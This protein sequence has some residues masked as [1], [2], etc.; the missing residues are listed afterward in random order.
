MSRSNLFT[1][2]TYQTNT[3]GW[4]ATQ[5]LNKRIVNSQRSSTTATITTDTDHGF[6]VGDSVTISGTN[7]NSA[8]HG[9]YT[10][11]A[12][13]TS[14]TFR[15]TTATSGTIT[16][17]ADTGTATVFGLAPSTNTKTIINSER[18]STTALITTSASHGFAVGDVV[19][20]AGTN[21]NTPLHGTYT[22]TGV[23][24]DTTFTY[25][26]STSGSI[27]SA[28]DTGTAVI[29]TTSL[30]RITSDYFV[31]SSSLEITKSA[32]ANSGVITTNRVA[33]TALSKYAISG[34]VKVPS[35]QESGSFNIKA[36]WY[37]AS[38]A[39]SIVLVSDGT[40]T[41]STS[42]SGWKR[43]TAVFTAP[44][45][46]THANFAFIQTTAGTS[47]K[48]FLLDAVLLEEATS[49]GEFF[50]NSNQAN[51]TSKVNLSLTPLPQP[52]L[53]GMKLQ[54]DISLNDFTFNTID[55][56]GVVWVVTDLGGWW[57]HP[58]SEI[59]DIARGWGDGSYDVKGRYNAR[60]IT[61]EGVILTPD[62]SLLAAARD[63]LVAA[64]NLVHSGAWLKTNEGSSVRASYVRL[65]G[66]V[67]IQTV[68]ARGRTEFSIGLRA[69][70]PIK[71]KWNTVDPVY[72]Y[73]NTLITCRGS[74]TSEDGTEIIEN[75][76]NFPV[77]VYLTITGPLTG[78]A[79]ISNDTTE[80]FI[81]IT[82]T[83]RA[84]TTKTIN[85]RGL[86]DNL[87]TVSTTTAHGIVAGDIVTISG[88]GSPYDGLATV[89][90][91]PTTSTFTYE[92][93]GSNVAYGA[94]S[95]SVAYGPDVL[96]IDTYDKSV[97]LNGEYSGARS[98][99]EVY[100]D[101]VTLYPG[102]NTISFYDNGNT[103]NPTATLSVDYRSGWLS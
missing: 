13:P 65:S 43:V 81:T 64:T 11:T 12:V 24:S 95:G 74:S 93:S 50:T 52:H 32:Q 29:A 99:L 25:T 75:E 14:V 30:A 48:T 97:F 7:G 28:P 2:P 70:D 54:A 53:T 78:P 92:T 86:T 59:P 72:G 90:S 56:Y 1:N 84:A 89:L 94:A 103:V 15:Y 16:S 69:A 87:V 17:A 77:S 42:S 9:T 82:D 98:K 35:G 73:N 62:P 34:Y 51:E 91:I 31:G 100:N 67:E 60:D 76:G 3:T 61:F 38:T 63:R 45:A 8:L 66:D 22:I 21:G 36:I 71:Y 5:N 19:T 47:A 18:T 57:Q 39:G 83:L 102:N 79:V 20:I 27:T 44:T 88:L 68:N 55:E 46:S 4:S 33:I 37:N 10:I 58:S 85:N 49:V 96:E 101:W 26:T 80:E 41:S 6:L 23:P 40:A